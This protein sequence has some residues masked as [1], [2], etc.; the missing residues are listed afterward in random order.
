MAEL[1]GGDVP[2]SA[3]VVEGVNPAAVQFQFEVPDCPRDT[4]MKVTAPDGTQLHIK[5]PQSV[6]A[7]DMMVMVKGEDGKWTVKHVV[8]P[9]AVASV[10]RFDGKVFKKSPEELEADLCGVT[11]VKVRLET[12]K[13]PIILRIVANWA[14]LGAQRFMQLVT[15]N[16]YTDIAIYRAVPGFLAQFGVINDT[17]RNEKYKEIPDDVL[18]GV[19]IVEGSVCFAA[20]GANTRRYTVCIFLGEFPQL[21]QNTW[22][23]PIGKVDPS[24]M[25][26]LRSLYTG[27]GDMPQCDGDG[28]DPIQLED[29]G[30]DYIHKNF[31]KCDFVKSAKWV[32]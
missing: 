7:G 13:G 32:D 24:S 26:V 2:S 15:D 11:A 22:E 6:L 28:P 5:R 30:N 31:P 16:Y 20:S 8:R 4:V 17:Q 9:E 29:Q 27:Y 18:S 21:G 12:T 23:T 19:P 3:A 1:E 10:D 25:D 14:P